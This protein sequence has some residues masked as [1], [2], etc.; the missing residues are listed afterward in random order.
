L[1]NGIFL[2]CHIVNNCYIADHPLQQTVQRVTDVSRRDLTRLPVAHRNHRCI[3][4]RQF[5]SGEKT[6]SHLSQDTVENRSW[7]ALLLAAAMQFVPLCTWA[8]APAS[9]VLAEP[10]GAA[11]VNQSAQE[12]GIQVVVVTAQKRE[13]NIQDVGVAVTPLNESTLALINPADATTL[14]SVV[15]SMQVQQYSPA[16]TIYNIRGVS[17]NDFS[18]FQ[19]GPVAFYN[20]EIYIGALGAIAGQ[21]FDVQRIEVLAG[22]QGTLFGRNANGGLVQVLTNKPSSTWEGY[23]TLTGGSYDQV[24]SEAAIG[25]PIS[26]SIRF[27][28]SETT[29]DFN[30]YVQN[31]YPGSKEG[32]DAKF[33]AGRGQLEFDVAPGGLLRLKVEYMRNDHESGDALNGGVAYQNA[34]G[35]GVFV[36]PNQNYYGTCNGCN[37]LGYRYPSDPFVQDADEAGLF[38]RSFW[39]VAAHYDQHLGGVLFTSI[40]DYQ[41]L[42]TQFHQDFDSSPAALVQTTGPGLLTQIDQVSEEL[43]ASGNV[44][45]L[46]WVAGLYALR[47]HINGISSV[48]VDP[49]YDEWL[50]HVPYGLFSQTIDYHANSTTQTLAP[51]AQAEYKLTDV[52]TL[53]GGLRYN[54]DRK[55]YQFTSMIDSLFG[56]F[57]Y[58]FNARRPDLAHQTFNA[59]SGKIQL[60]AHPNADTLLYVGVNRGI[61]SGGFN[62]P[63][64]FPT[65]LT[66]QNP[67]ALPAALAA[68]DRGMVFGEEVLTNYEGGFK[69]TLANNRATLNGTIY[70]YD[71]QGYQAFEYI[72]ANEQIVNLPAKVTGAELQL[73]ARPVPSVNISAFVDHF[74]DATIEN[75]TL[76]DG[77]VADRRLPQTPSWSFGTTASLQVP[78]GNLGF[79]TLA[80][81]W[82]YNTSQNM[83]TFNSPVTNESP[84]AVG[85]VRLS[86]QTTARNLEFAFFVNNVTDRIYRIYATDNSFSTTVEEVYGRPRW[87][88]GSVTYRF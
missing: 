36:G 42:N 75:V 68:F 9:N 22:P 10:Q 51:F 2:Y 85:D 44:D 6:M 25:G 26:D 43:R 34:Q 71:Y 23:A 72:A 50:F 14:P 60:E 54:D 58:D 38:D 76:P 81:N 31:L 27:R 13:Q 47:I 18:N 49:L 87:F 32:G 19:E 15:P 3:P 46:T 45:R 69:L 66:I 67:A 21:T 62:T 64:S 56:D 74:F 16:Q 48:I 11:G 29:N 53:I 70:H 88:G 8:Q 84:Y 55:D 17:Q 77:E 20:D 37:P 78:L 12:E 52:F 63:N 79:A 59:W 82:K 1:K 39:N 73:T 7:I 35:L 4:A 86:Y 65:P 40:T 24:S 5:F 28:L 30:G 80:T 61:K 83:A 57:P 41:S 33:Y